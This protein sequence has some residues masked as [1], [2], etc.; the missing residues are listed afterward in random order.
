MWPAGGGFNGVFVA[1]QVAALRRLG[2]EVDVEV[3]ARDHGKADYLLAGARVRRRARAGDYD[4]VHAHYGLTAFAGRFAGPVP[5]VLSLHGSDVNTPWQRRV[6]K[7]AGR[8]YAARIYVSRRLADTAGDPAAEVIPAG[9]DFGLF[10]PRD[11]AAAKAELRLPADEKVVLFGGSPANAVKGYDV[12]LDVLAALRTRGVPVRELVLVGHDQDRTAVVTK[13]A[14]A[15]ALLFTSRR[16]A[17]G[18]PMVVKEAA[19]MGLPVVSVDVG[20]VAEVLAGVN[21]SAVVP[22]PPTRAGLVEALATRLIEVLA[23]GRRSDGRER[24]AW[25]DSL[26]I[27]RRV[28]GV[29]RTAVAGTKPALAGKG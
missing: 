24:V 17:E 18:S 9:V 2:H 19:A 29:Y 26:A 7:L 22:F 23:D 15:D 10:T 16:G 28:A 20:D 5:R 12:F 8:G 11:Q 4:V 27:A 25:A 13:M 14:A 1:E 21:P 3:V 6:T